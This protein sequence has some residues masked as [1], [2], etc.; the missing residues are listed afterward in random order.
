MPKKPTDKS[1]DAATQLA[2]PARKRKAPESAVAAPKHKPARR[3]SKAAP[4]AAPEFDLAAHQG[5][6]AHTAYLLWLDRGC[7]E[8]HAFEDWL[9]AEEQVRARAAGAA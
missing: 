3:A 9:Q 6:I 4:A 2:K 8:G 1:I 7:Q 5:E